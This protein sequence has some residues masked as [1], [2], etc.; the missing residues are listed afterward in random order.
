MKHPQ[1]THFVSSATP[2]QGAHPTAR[3][4]RFRGCPGM[5]CSAAFGALVAHALPALAGTME[6]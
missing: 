5:A 6:N 2:L 1:A 3:P 4:S